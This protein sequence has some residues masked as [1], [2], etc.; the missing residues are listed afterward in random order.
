MLNKEFDMNNFMKKAICIVQSTVIILALLSGCMQQSGAAETS[1]QEAPVVTTAPVRQAKDGIQTLLVVCLDSFDVPRDSGAYRNGN[2]ADSILLIVI[3]EALSKTTALQLN[4]DT[5]VPFSTLGTSEASEIPLGLV[6]SYGSGGSDSC[7]SGSKAVSNLLGGISIDHYMTF[8]MDS[9]AIVNDMVGGI[10]VSVTEDF[11]E[12]SPE[13]VKGESVTLS[14]GNSV[15]FFRLRADTDVANEAH[16]ERQRQ[17]ITGLYL[18][19]IES[20]KQEDFLTRL[21]L[22]LG[23]RFSTDLT[24]SQMAQLLQSMG[25]YQLDE[26]IVTI[27]G[28]AGKSDGQFQFHVDTDSLNQT[29]ER[30]FFE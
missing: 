17:Y 29:V 20:A 4:P 12:E 30:L 11:P 27:Q 1:A 8:T 25:E 5:M 19:F 13:F 22:Q 23:E 3:D 18:P 26:A 6:Y 16:M 21:T 2:R 10:T 15:E 14:G 7:L 28:S 9:V 24:L